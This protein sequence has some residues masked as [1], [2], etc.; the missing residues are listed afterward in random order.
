MPLLLP[1]L[2]LLQSGVGS[3]SPF[4]VP[5]LTI[6]DPYTHHD[7]FRNPAGTNS[8]YATTTHTSLASVASYDVTG[9]SRS[10]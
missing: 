8:W 1:L 10:R 6:A 9:A 4:C 2:L 7:G 3:I 5:A